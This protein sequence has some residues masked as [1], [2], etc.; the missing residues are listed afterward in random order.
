[1]DKVLFVAVG[2]AFGAVS[3]YAVSGWA[4]AL[5]GAGFPYGT[6][7]VNV[8]GCFLLGALMHVGT[9][10]ELIPEVWRVGLSIGFLGGLTTFST[11][12]YETYVGLEE[13]QWLVP[14]GNVAA[15]LIL[16]L[17]AVWAGMLLARIW[18]GGA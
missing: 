6:L 8:I 16:G 18:V 10:T 9:A 4:L 7:A 12:G 15:N 17:T 2:G 1:M 11:F 13:G 5:F 3:R 14:V